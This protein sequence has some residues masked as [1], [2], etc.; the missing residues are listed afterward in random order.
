MSTKAAQD[1]IMRG[2]AAQIRAGNV[3]TTPMRAGDALQAQLEA[4][5]TAQETLMALAR[6]GLMNKAA[7]QDKFVFDANNLTERE[8][9]ELVA[10]QKDFVKNQIETK[11][12]ESELQTMQAREA[13][14]GERN[15]YA[16]NALRR[17][18]AIQ[19]TRSSHIIQRLRDSDTSFVRETSSDKFKSL[20]NSTVRLRDLKD[21]LYEDRVNKILAETRDIHLYDKFVLIQKQA[22][23]RQQR[24]SSLQSYIQAKLRANAYTDPEV[25]LP[26][27]FKVSPEDMRK[28]FEFRDKTFRKGLAY[29]TS[30]LIVSVSSMLMSLI[31]VYFVYEL[32]EAQNMSDTRNIWRIGSWG[33]MTVLIQ[34]FLHRRSLSKLS[35][36][37]PSSVVPGWVL[38]TILM[39][40]CV[41]LL[42]NAKNVMNES[43]YKNARHSLFG[44]FLFYLI[45]T[46]AT[47]HAIVANHSKLDMSRS[48]VRT[49]GLAVFGTSCL[50]AMMFLTPIM[51]ESPQRCGS[52]S[53]SSC[54]AR[55]K[56]STLRSFVQDKAYGEEGRLRDCIDGMDV[57]DSLFTTTLR[58][59]LG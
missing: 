25:S 57:H 30:A 11:K 51:S 16:D 7:T 2:A 26:Q 39:G 4:K 54:L 43:R 12:Y 13:F 8:R 33:A 36:P 41:Y 32:S 23:N 49:Q 50:I 5:N 47:L 1:A 52:I 34:L 14:K 40:G 44:I 59:T 31:A 38:L 45:S 24:L 58:Q 42:K 19:P 10:I 48:S 56:P 53:K 35:P 15:G 3:D 21:E 28:L 46:T 37:G 18:M 55:M 22:K 6:Q 29:S 9:R 17:T 27:L 20:R